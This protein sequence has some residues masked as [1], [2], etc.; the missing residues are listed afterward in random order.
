MGAGCSQGWGLGGASAAAAGPGRGLK[1]PGDPGGSFREW[2]L[3]GART[4][5]AL[6][7]G[8]PSEPGCPP[9]TRGGG[10]GQAPPLQSPGAVCGLRGAGEGRKQ[11]LQGTPAWPAQDQL[12]TLLW[13]PEPALPACSEPNAWPPPPAP[14][15]PRA[16]PA[17]PCPR[18]VLPRTLGPPPP[19]LPC[20]SALSCARPLQKQGESPSPDLSSPAG[21]PH[22]L[23]ASSW[24]AVTGSGPARFLP[25]W[26]QLSP[27]SALGAA[28]RPEGT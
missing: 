15:P 2:P 3:R 18:A 6:T 9:R 25:P 12:C 22:P 4:P 11:G 13:G 17:R 26:V 10:G 24:S 23:S 16:A 19:L 14:A 1:S 21:A 27:N 5:R 7:Q 28:P 20:R 8:G